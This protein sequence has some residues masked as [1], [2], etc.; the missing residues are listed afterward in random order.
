MSDVAGKTVVITGASRGIGEASARLFA[1]QGANVVL[2]A[3]SESAINA[4]SAEI[5]DAALAI[6]C[7]VSSYADME[8]AVQTA[9]ESYGKVDVL[10]SNA[11]V[12]EPISHLAT[13]DPAEWARAIDINL[14]GVFNGMRAVLPAMIKAKS[15]TILTISSGAAHNA[16]EAWS[17]YCSSKAGAAMLTRMA[18]LENAAHGL[19]CMG[20]S[21]GTV[22]TQMQKEIKTSGINAVSQLDWDIH[23]PA[24]WPAQTLLWMCG[25]DADAWLGEEISLRDESIRAR[26]G[27]S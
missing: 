22:A 19:R 17:H 2:L 11:G 23:I 26:V 4:I 15:G 21:P 16:I 5:G 13:A 10:I 18:H 6:A 27:L 3:R 12:I 9:C 20:L 1:N 8:K 7:D 25:T 24:E 14:T